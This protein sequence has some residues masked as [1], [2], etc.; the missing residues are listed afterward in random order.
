MGKVL[1]LVEG[2]KLTIDDIIQNKLAS[3]EVDITKTEQ[4]YLLEWSDLL[5]RYIE[6]FDYDVKLERAHSALI[7]AHMQIYAWENDLTLEDTE[8]SEVKDEC[9]EPDQE[10]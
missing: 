6:M 5:I 1:T 3:L 4:N 7:Y 10:P 8:L 2:D 9:Q